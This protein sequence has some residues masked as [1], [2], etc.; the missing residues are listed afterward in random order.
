MLRT[1]SIA[2]SLSPHFAENITVELAVKSLT[3]NA[4]CSFQ[5]HGL[6]SLVVFEFATLARI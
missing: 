4:L 6:D 2:E 3:P 5:A 1:V